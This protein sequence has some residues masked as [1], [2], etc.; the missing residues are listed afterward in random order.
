MKVELKT[1]IDAS[2]N[3]GKLLRLFCRLKENDKRD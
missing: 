3:R 2:K 1:E